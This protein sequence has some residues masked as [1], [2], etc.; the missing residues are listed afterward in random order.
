MITVEFSPLLKQRTVAFC[1]DELNYHINESYCADEYDDE[2]LAQIE[3]LY[4]LGEKDMAHDY[5]QQYEQE[6]ERFANDPSSCTH[7]EDELQT[8][9]AG[10]LEFWTKLTSKEIPTFTDD[11]DR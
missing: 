5:M 7:T 3:I 8:M 4:R 2:I 9:K 11:Q 10:L 6:L 1:D